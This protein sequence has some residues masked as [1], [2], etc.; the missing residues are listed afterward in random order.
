VRVRG[1][2][3]TDSITSTDPLKDNL[4]LLKAVPTENTP[5][6]ITTAKLVN[7]LSM[8]IHEA[9]EKHPINS[10]RKKQGKAVA[11]VVLLRGCGT[12]IEAPT[13]QERH[14]LKPFLIAPTCIIAGLGMSL[15]IDILKAPGATGDYHT[16]LN[17]KADTLVSEVTKE[18]SPYTFGFIHVKAVDDAG[19]DRSVG[20]KVR[21]LQDVDN[22]ISRLLSNLSLNEK[23]GNSFSICIT[24]DHSTPV[25]SGDHSFEPVP[26]AIAK[27]SDAYG[28]Y[29]GKVASQSQLRDEVGKFSEIDAARGV[30]GRFC[31]NQV[32]P[33]INFF[34]TL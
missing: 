30:L 18:G 31:G 6:A 13:F 23:Q 29:L 24:G 11:N 12:L 16:N 9:L 4:Q 14:G 25:L 3:L 7:E 17:S 21:F 19:H 15:G 2:G 5:Q 28:H 32:M 8:T 34:I 1:P 10:E 22:M 20:L 27:V 26:F 33:I